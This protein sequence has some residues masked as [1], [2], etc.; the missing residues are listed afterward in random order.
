[1]D[2]DEAISTHAAT[3]YVLGE[4]DDKERDAFE[5]HMF[6]CPECAKQVILHAERFFP[7]P[8]RFCRMPLRR[9]KKMR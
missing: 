6:A 4:M 3:R 2:H 5:D 7:A 1:M 8:R 9:R